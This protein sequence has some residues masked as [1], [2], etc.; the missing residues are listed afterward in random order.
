MNSLL[1]R[2]PS[3]GGTK[4]LGASPFSFLASTSAFRPFAD[5]RLRASVDVLAH[6]GENLVYLVRCRI[7]RNVD[8]EV[9]VYSRCRWGLLGPIGWFR[10]LGFCGRTRVFWVCALGL[11]FVIIA[12]S[13]FAFF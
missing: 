3:E 2:V 6:A 7:R 1:G 4:L 8:F 11:R 13:S 10:L 9:N 5:I 12:P